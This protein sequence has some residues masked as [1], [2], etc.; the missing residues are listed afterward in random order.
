MHCMAFQLPNDTD[1]AVKVART[2]TKKGPNQQS[3]VIQKELQE[4]LSSLGSIEDGIKT[5]KEPTE[6]SSGD[7]A[8]D[9]VANEHSGDHAIACLQILFVPSCVSRGIFLDFGTL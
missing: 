6:G 5:Q 4:E 2:S 3:R 7:D 1:K 9:I 8:D